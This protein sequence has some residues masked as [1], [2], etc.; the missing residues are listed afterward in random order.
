MSEAEEYLRKNLKGIFMSI[1]SDVI[2]EKPLDPVNKS[3]YKF[4][5]LDIVYD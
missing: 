4:T 3:L 5:L 1:V 2:I